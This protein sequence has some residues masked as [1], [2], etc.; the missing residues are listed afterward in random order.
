ML[1]AKFSPQPLASSFVEISSPTFMANEMARPQVLSPH[2]LQSKFLGMSVAAHVLLMILLLS[3]AAG[4]YQNTFDEP[5]QQVFDVVYET[6]HSAPDEQAPVISNASEA[7]AVPLKA[8]KVPQDIKKSIL[9]K[10]QSSTNKVEQSNAKGNDSATDSNQNLLASGQ[11]LKIDMAKNENSGGGLFQ[12]LQLISSPQFIHPP[13][14][15]V[16]PPPSIANGEEGTVMVRVLIDENGSPKDIV[17]WQSSGYGLLDKSAKQAVMKWQ[18]V[19]QKQNG[20]FVAAW[21]EVPVHFVL[22]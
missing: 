5:G 3:G 9:A 6:S 11:N 18:F 22:R 17:V 2:F 1:I 19:P 7:S 10:T 4:M 13:A 16:Y 15:P 20:S 8:D 14:Q 21:V 12:G